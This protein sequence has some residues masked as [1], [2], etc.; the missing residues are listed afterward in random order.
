MPLVPLAN[1]N[2]GG[3]AVLLDAQG[4]RLMDPDGR[5]LLGTPSGNCTCLHRQAKK[6]SDD[7]DADLWLPLTGLPSTLAIAKDGIC[8]HFNE[9]NNESCAPGTIASNYLIIPGCADNA[10][11]YYYRLRRCPA[12]GGGLTTRYVRV[13]GVSSAS[14]VVMVDPDSGE[15]YR[16][17]SP[18]VIPP[19]GATKHDTLFEVSGCVASNCCIVPER[20]LVTVA[21]VNIV[22]A[23]TLAGN[24]AYLHTS[25]S[26]NGTFIL[27]KVPGLNEWEY[28]GSGVTAEQRSNPGLNTTGNLCEG[29]TLTTS[30][31][32]LGL[33][34]VTGNA[35]VS[36]IENQSSSS[37]N[38]SPNY[39]RGGADFD[40]WRMGVPVVFGPNT[41]SSSSRMGEDGT[42]TAVP[43]P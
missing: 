16:L 27:T 31:N 34:V 30:Y 39:F 6:C 41:A 4:R 38:N 14:A 26:P 15:C 25:G 1:Q 13:S 3:H 7:S 43:I 5:L 20:L 23:R 42:F 10:C 22:C 32:Y 21:G 33:R 28:R 18:P 12:D 40:C 8:Y 24:V 36:A 17:V 19:G 35:F 9:G 11:S 29:G 37:I 2:V